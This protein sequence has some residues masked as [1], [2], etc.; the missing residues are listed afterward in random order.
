MSTDQF[1]RAIRLFVTVVFIATVL[2][3]VSPVRAVVAPTLNF[4]NN[5]QPGGSGAPLAIIWATPPGSY[6]ETYSVTNVTTGASMSLSGIFDL[7]SHLQYGSGSVAVNAGD[8][9]RI[10]FTGDI[11][12]IDYP[13]TTSTT[14]TTSL[15][16]NDG[17]CN[18]E[19]DQALAV[20]SDDEGGYN[21]YAVNVGVGYFAMHITKQQLDANPDKGKDYLIAQSEGVQ[22]FRLAGGVLQANRLKP[23]GKAYVYRIGAC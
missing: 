17:R 4:L 16:F 15:A 7:A 6:S 11:N 21:F 10:T 1:I 23:D 18:Q 22:L 3:I 12:G 19:A 8:V 20:Y 5:C 13:C 14:S 2:C 9:I